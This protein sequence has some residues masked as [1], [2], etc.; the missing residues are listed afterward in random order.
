[1]QNVSTPAGSSSINAVAQN[2]NTGANFGCIAT[3]VDLTNSQT[4]TLELGHVGYSNFL[5]SRVANGIVNSNVD[6]PS[7]PFLASAVYNQGLTIF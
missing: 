2:I 3:H 6:I 4:V 1:V 7:T 5:T